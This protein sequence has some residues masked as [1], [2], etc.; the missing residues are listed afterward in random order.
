MWVVEKVLNS[1]VVLVKNE[2][3]KE[4]ILLKKGI[5]YG[6]KPGETVATGSEEERMF[7]PLEGDNQNKLKELMD[8]IPAVYLEATREIVDYAQQALNTTLNEHIYLALTDH[9]HFAVQRQKENMIILNRVFWEIKNF[10]AEEFK[11]GLFALD[12]VE[13]YT[14][15]RLPEEEAANVAFHLVNAQ[16]SVESQY[17]A[18][19]AAKLISTM[20]TLITYAM[21]KQPDKESVHYSRFVSHLQYFSERFFTGKMLEDEEDFLYRQMQSGYPKAVDCAEKIRSYIL[22]DYQILIPNEEVAYLAVHIQRLY[23]R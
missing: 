3:G 13:K 22:K 14:G 18:L 17:D 11:V 23:S 5:G 9:L 4:S 20:V 7:I 2:A 16:K 21:Q 6:R 19:R 12:V 8:S 10:Y 15:V 1:S